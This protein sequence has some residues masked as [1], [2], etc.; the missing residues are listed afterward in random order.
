MQKINSR[1]K[2]GRFEREMSKFLSKNT[3]YSWNR[4]PFSGAIATIHNSSLSQLKGD[5]YCEDKMFQDI[6]VE[7]KSYKKPVLMEDIFKKSSNLNAWLLQTIEEAAEQDWILFFKTNNH[8]TLYL[9]NAS[10]VIQRLKLGSSYIKF[11]TYRFG[12]LE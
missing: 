6:L 5:V 1:D 12:R 8:M 9:T 7:C 11:H 2:G 10:S 3:G 4:T